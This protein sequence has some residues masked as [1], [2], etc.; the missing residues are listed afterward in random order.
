MQRHERDFTFVSLVYKT[1]QRRAFFVFCGGQHGGQNF[2]VLKQS[3]S[4]SKHPARKQN[5][6]GY[7]YSVFIWVRIFCLNSFH[8]DVKNSGASFVMR[9][10]STVSLFL[11]S[12]Y[13]VSIADLCIGTA[14]YM[15]GTRQSATYSASEIVSSFVLPSCFCQQ[16]FRSSTCHIESNVIK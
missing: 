7:Y 9:I 10:S 6:A 15:V 16:A 8:C 11:C 3:F 12:R 2:V 4:K 1:G 13:A 5:R 14:L